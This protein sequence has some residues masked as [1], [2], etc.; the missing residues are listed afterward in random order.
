MK[1]ETE[2][3]LIKTLQESPGIHKKIVNKIMS[4][5]SFPFHFKIYTV[6]IFALYCYKKITNSQ[7]LILF[8]SQLIIFTIKC[9]VKRKRP[10]EVNKDIKLLE[11]MSFDPYSFP[12]GHTLNAFMLYYIMKKNIGINLNLLPYLVGLSR[13]YLGVHYPSDI[14]GGIILSKI[15]LKLHNF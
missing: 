12:S 3:T 8:S 11:E 6:I 4:L 2:L 7:L 10:F 14:L 9:V 1:V 5:I 13:I 15:I